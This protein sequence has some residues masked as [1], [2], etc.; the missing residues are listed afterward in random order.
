MHFYN[1]PIL[2]RAIIN[3]GALWQMPAE[4]KSLYLSFDDGP[5]ADITYWILSEL[6]KYQ[7]QATFFCVGDNVEKYP[8]IYKEIKKKGHAVGNHTFN[9]FNGWSTETADYVENINK[10]NDVIGSPLF[11]PPYGKMRPAQ[12]RK[13]RELGY[14]IV[15]W[16]V[17]TY[18]FENNLDTWQSW[19]KIIRFTRPGGILVF[20][21]NIK[22]FE[23]LKI[24]L[25]QTLAYFSNK[26]YSFKAIS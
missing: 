5:S 14:K 7:A 9:H 21:D 2:A 25:P 12:I 13:V 17:L 22:A 19:K 8:G 15:M 1:T 24:L 18:D 20:H 16:S 11:R 26:G 4:E 10:A 6:E 23:N 3:P